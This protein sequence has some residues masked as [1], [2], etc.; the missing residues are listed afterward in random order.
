MKAECL[1]KD[2]PNKLYLSK[3]IREDQLDNL[4][5]NEP[6]T[7]KIVGPDSWLVVQNLRIALI[8]M[9]VSLTLFV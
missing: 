5:L 9:S 8:K 3:Q 1:R 2:S 7:L 4:E 6:I